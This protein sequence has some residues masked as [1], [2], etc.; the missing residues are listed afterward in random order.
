MHENNLSTTPD[1]YFRGRGAQIN[2]HNKYLQGEYNQDHPEGIDEWEQDDE[3]TRIIE[4]Q[5]KT[6]VNKVDSPDVGMYYSVNPYQGCEHG[7]TYCY[8]RN[9]HQ[10]WGYSAGRDFEQKIIVK[11]NAPELFRKF[12]SRKNWNAVP[13]SFSG[14]T[15]CYQPVER[16]LQI[17]RQLLRVALDYRQPVGIITKNALILRDLDILQEMARLNLVAVYL[18]INSLNEDLRRLLE[19]RTATYSQRLQTI[20]K[21]S[22]AGIPTG[23]MNAPIIPGLNDQDSPAVLAAAREHGALRA[24]YTIVRLNDAVKLIFHD[25]LHKNFPD[26]ADKVWHLIES[27][28]GG[29]V[30]DS[31]FG[32]RMRGEGNIASLIED[33]FRMHTRK[34]GLNQTE[35]NLDTTQFRVPQAQLS[36][37]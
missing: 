13:V 5:A 18:S 27:L 25:W 22:Q 15:D 11:R 33:Q 34:L 23:V 16:K 4:T 20:Q 35:I 28:H 17:T 36:L 1:T 32:K 10:Y 7:C 30:N 24:G 29:Q 6:L 37:F 19:P 8:A 21:L 31:R 2:P 9:S 12:I 26:R 14:N 3:P